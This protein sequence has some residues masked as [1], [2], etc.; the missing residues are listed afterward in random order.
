MA[1]RDL[2]MKVPTEVWV[3][4]TNGGDSIGGFFWN[5][6]ELEAKCDGEKY[7][8]ISH[9]NGSYLDRHEKLDLKKIK[10]ISGSIYK[11]EIHITFDRLLNNRF[12]VYLS[13]KDDLKEEQ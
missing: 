7:D 9:E 1:E 3:K 11:K 4:S 13:Q 5:I 6:D 2:M 12:K 8:R 10:P